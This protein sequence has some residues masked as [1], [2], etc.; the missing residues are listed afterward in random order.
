MYNSRSTRI[1]TNDEPNY[2]YI[3]YSLND[4]L[5]KTKSN[6]SIK[7]EQ[8][9][10]KLMKKDV[11]D[12]SKKLNGKIHNIE[13][14]DIDNMNILH[15]LCLNPSNEYIKEYE[16]AVSKCSNNLDTSFCIVPRKFREK[17]ESLR[18]TLET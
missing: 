8:F 2:E 12:K 6:T 4:K 17:Y 1:S 14:C 18:G 7:V 11:L 3:N 10:L 15:N 16:K 9:Y 13:K 5:E